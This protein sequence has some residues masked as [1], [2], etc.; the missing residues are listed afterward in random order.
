FSMI[1][2]D[3]SLAKRRNKALYV[4][5][6]DRFF[7]P[8]ARYLPTYMLDEPRY[9]GGLAR[10]LQTEPPMSGWVARQWDPQVRHRFQ[11]LLK[12]LARQFDGRI[13]GLV[14]T[15]TAVSIDKDHPPAGFTCDD[16]FEA[17]KEKARVAR[18]AFAHSYVVQYVNFWPC[19]FAN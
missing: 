9:G 4:E 2:H 5:V 18:D 19:E 11:L 3:L 6:L 10:Q 7:Q 12:A 16:Y 15:E 17:E 1:E 14:L 8:S 13:A